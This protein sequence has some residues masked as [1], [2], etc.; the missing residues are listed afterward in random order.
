M[1]QISTGAVVSSGDYT[2]DGGQLTLTYTAITGFEASTVYN[3]A[4][5]GDKLTLAD[6]NSSAFEVFTRSS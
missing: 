4:I 6:P 3:Y 5:D 2:T 1:T